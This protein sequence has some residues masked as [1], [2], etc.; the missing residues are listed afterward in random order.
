MI[1]KPKKPSFHFS[2]EADV[3]LDVGDIWPDGDAPENP[4][5]EHVLE[6]IKKA[7]GAQWILENWNFIDDLG[8]T[9]SDGKRGMVVP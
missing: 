7:G 1:D 5:L 4:T 2:I 3:S 9:I 6:V 8:V